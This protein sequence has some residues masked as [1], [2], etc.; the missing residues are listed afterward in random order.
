M[1][2]KRISGSRLRSGGGGGSGGRGV[3]STPL[4][5]RGVEESVLW[6]EERPEEEE[7]SPLSFDSRSTDAQQH[8]DAD[9]EKDDDGDGQDEDEDGVEALPTPAVRETAESAAA[10]KELRSQ[11]FDSK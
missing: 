6:A 7:C 1:M 5:R 11:D 4:G 2:E 3:A 10:R 8:D 9:E